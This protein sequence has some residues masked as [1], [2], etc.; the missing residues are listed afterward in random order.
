MIS[1]I[2][3]T[4]DRPE[5]LTLTLSALAMLD[6]GALARV[7]G[8]ELIVVDNASKHP[9]VLPDKLANGIAARVIFR[10]TN[11]GAAARNHAAKTANGDWL[12]MLDDDSAPIDAGFVDALLAADDSIAAIG[13]EILLRD[14]AHEAGGLPEV[15]I[16]CGAAIRRGPYLVAGGYDPAFGYYAEEYDLCARL[17]LA[18]LRVVHDRRF[19]VVHRKT[20]DGRDMNLILRRLVRNNGWVEQRY[21]PERIREDILARTVG[22]YRLIA[23]REQAT[24]GFEEGLRE[25][26]QTLHDQPRREMS[27]DVYDRFIGFT[28]ARDRLETELKRTHATR[29]I[30][31]DDG[32]NA[33]VVKRAIEEC[34]VQLGRHLRDLGTSGALVVGTLSPGPLTDAALRRA[35]VAGPP[36]ISPWWWHAEAAA[37]PASV[38]AAVRAAA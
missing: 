21:A 9:P 3:P 23:E 18:G 36:V 10:P 19:R 15:I 4:R 25:L 17:L 5:H 8:A 28:A 35:G 14:G 32:K 16:G 30:T 37:Q 26:R 24:A 34:G 1:F 12:I 31:I 2:L 13:A 33:W 20:A 22:R 11:E 27:D 6:A 38:D 29:A 7:G